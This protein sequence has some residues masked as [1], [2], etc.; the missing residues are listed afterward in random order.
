MSY[1]WSNQYIFQQ[2]K[3]FPKIA[4]KDQFI[5]AEAAAF[6]RNQSVCEQ[7]RRKGPVPVIRNFLCNLRQHMFE[8][9]VE[10]LYPTI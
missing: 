4:A 7:N 8:G 10:V 2:R 3:G 1:I 6:L 9:A 5:A